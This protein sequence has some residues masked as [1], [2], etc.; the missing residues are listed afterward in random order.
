MAGAATGQGR[1]LNQSADLRLDN[2]QVVEAH[3]AAHLTAPLG[4]NYRGFL[5]S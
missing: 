2:V 3:G 4:L 1:R 5:G